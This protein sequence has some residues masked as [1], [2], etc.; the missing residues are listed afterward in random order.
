MPWKLTIGVRETVVA[1]R[2]GALKGHEQRTLSSHIL[3][4]HRHMVIAT[5]LSSLFCLAALQHKPDQ[6]RM[7]P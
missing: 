2:L 3:L 6:S 5:I 4:C 7:L 1:H